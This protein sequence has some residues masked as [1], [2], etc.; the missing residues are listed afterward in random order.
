MTKTSLKIISIIFGVIAIYS[1]IQ[2]IPDRRQKTLTAFN[3][4]YQFT[5]SIHISE[6]F[7]TDFESSYGIHLNLLN[8]NHKGIVDTI[9][10]MKID[11]KILKNGKPVE[12]YG[13]YKNGYLMFNGN[14][15]LTSFMPEEN[16]E[17][18]LKLDLEDNNLIRK[19]KINIATDVPGPSYDLLFEREFKWIDWTISGLAIFIALIT[20]YFGFRKKASR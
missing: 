3:K 14:A 5:E 6:K 1:T 9:L 2:L 15:Q 13:D 4:E 12:L 11:L 20:G 16:T 8:S 17:Y 19:I 18:E 10:P 7:T